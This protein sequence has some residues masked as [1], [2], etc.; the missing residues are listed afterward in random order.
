MLEFENRNTIETNA[1]KE[2][3]KEMR[4]EVEGIKAEMKT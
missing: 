1:I 3:T 2:N 4:R